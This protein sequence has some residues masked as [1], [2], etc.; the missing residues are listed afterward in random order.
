VRCVLCVLWGVRTF[1]CS[2]SS[3]AF[4][5]IIDPVFFC[6]VLLRARKP[7][8]LPAPFWSVLLEAALATYLLSVLDAIELPS[9]AWY[10]LV[11]ITFQ[12]K[13]VSRGEP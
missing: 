12:H 13:V 7:I 4:L 5:A 10:S 6:T 8:A 11:D 9:L 3:C 2:S 1:F